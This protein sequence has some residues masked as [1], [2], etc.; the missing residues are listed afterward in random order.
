MDP[1]VHKIYHH[2][3]L[4]DPPKFT[5]TRIFGLKTNRLATLNRI[6]QHCD[7]PSSANF[8]H[9]YNYN[10]YNNYNNNYN[11]PPAA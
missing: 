4:Q 2:L 9:N 6:P 8:G 11:Y 3:P 1:S 7:Q 10:N 5:Q